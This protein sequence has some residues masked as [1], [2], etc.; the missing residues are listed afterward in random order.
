MYYRREAGMSS[1]ASAMY[2]SLERVLAKR[3]SRADAVEAATEIERHAAVGAGNWA[4]LDGDRA[5]ALRQWRRAAQL[6]D[7][8][9]SLTALRWTAT[10]A[11]MLARGVLERRLTV[12]GRPLPS[13]V[14]RWWRSGG[15]R[16]QPR[17][18]PDQD[19]VR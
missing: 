8:R 12:D 3:R 7:A 6:G 19:Q 14:V 10:V 2:D 11:P 13:Q 9:P 16:D 1:N 17:A 18:R 5:G 4:M 15:R